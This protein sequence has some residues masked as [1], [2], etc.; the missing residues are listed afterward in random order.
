[1][2]VDVSQFID[3]D[4]ERARLTKQQGE[5]AGRIKGLESKLANENFVSRAPADVVQA[6]RDTLADVRGQL[7]SVEEALAKLAMR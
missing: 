4:A 1:V 5:L 3:V 2:H 7:E 6:Q